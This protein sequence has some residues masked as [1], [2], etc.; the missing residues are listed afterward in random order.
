MVLVSLH[1][2]QILHLLTNIQRLVI[3]TAGTGKFTLPSNFAFDDEYT[4][5]CYWHAGTAA[6]LTSPSNLAFV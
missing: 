1:Y 4:K 6:K 5:T 3:G 2:H